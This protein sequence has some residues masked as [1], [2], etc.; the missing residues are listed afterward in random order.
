MTQP[1]KVAEEKEEKE[2]TEEGTAVDTTKP[3]L[4][5][6]DSIAEALICQICQVDYS[7]VCVCVCV[8]VSVT[9]LSFTSGNPARL[10]EVLL[11]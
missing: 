10:C 6:K 9:I 4:E 5:K 11:L 1:K 2:K 8:C 7:S 3:A